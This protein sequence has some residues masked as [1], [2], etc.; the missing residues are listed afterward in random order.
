MP[1]DTSVWGALTCTLRQELIWTCAVD[2]AFLHE[3]ALFVTLVR[4]GYAGKKEK[5]IFL[6]RVLTCCCLASPVSDQLVDSAY[7]WTILGAGVVPYIGLIMLGGKVRAH[8]PGLL[9]LTSWSKPCQIQQP[10]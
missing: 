2:D 1:L 9:S 7:G 8:R 10:M 3:D 4:D 6:V 5:E